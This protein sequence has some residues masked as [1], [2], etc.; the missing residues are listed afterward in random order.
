[1]PKF[2]LELVYV[3]NGRWNSGKFTYHKINGLSYFK[4]GLIR[5]YTQ[6]LFTHRC[7]LS[8]DRRKLFIAFKQIP[9]QDKLCPA[10]FDLCDRIL[11]ETLR[12]KYL[13]S[14]SKRRKVSP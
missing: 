2:H 9:E 7:I 11:I 13:T 8:S 4:C 12:A 3:L 5:N 1:M 6:E 14:L 10:C